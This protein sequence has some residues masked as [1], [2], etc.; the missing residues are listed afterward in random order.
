MIFMTVGSQMPFDRLT[1][2]MDQWAALHPEVSVFAQ[3][4]F[5]EYTPVNMKSVKTLAPAEF[6]KIMGECDLVVA[7]AGMGSV[8]SAC[9][10]G[11]PLVLLPRKGSLRETRNDHQ[12]ASARALEPRA[13]IS[14]AWEEA[15]LASQLD[16]FLA[17][18]IES[19]SRPAQPIEF[20]QALRQ[21]IES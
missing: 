2:A 8:I 15:D 17:R 5:S 3:I 13:G 19:T 18:D 11:K 20:I 1:I 12:L 7:H 9:E 21:F 4:G 14:V 10:F 6:K 16:Q